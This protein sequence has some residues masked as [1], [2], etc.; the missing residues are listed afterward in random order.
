MIPENL[1]VPL[2]NTAIRDEAF[3]EA[4]AKF[5]DI[6]SLVAPAISASTT[7]IGLSGSAHSR[8]CLH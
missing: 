1:A 6:K 7:A 2:V 5:V 4:A 8:T 3:Q